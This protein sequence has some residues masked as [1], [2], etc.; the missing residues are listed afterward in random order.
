MPEKAMKNWSYFGALLD[1]HDFD[2]S[3]QEIPI[4]PKPCM[5]SGLNNPLFW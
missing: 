3:E 1:K 5:P 4:P 2:Q